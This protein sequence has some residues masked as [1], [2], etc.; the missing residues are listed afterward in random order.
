MTETVWF[1]S[2]PSTALAE[3]E[4]ALRRTAAFSAYVSA[5]AAN[6]TASDANKEQQTMVLRMTSPVASAVPRP[7]M[8]DDTDS[9]GICDN[10]ERM[11]AK[12]LYTP[13]AA[14]LLIC[15]GVGCG[16]PLKVRKDAAPPPDA[17]TTDAPADAPADQPAT[18]DLPAP[19][20]AADPPP[21]DTLPPPGRPK[22]FR[23]D[24][25]TDRRAYVQLDQ[26][27]QGRTL[28]PSGWQDCFFFD[29][30]CLVSCD[31][32]KPGTTCCEQ[33]DAPLPSL[34]VVSPGGSLRIPWDASIRTKALGVCDACECQQRTP[35]TEGSFEAYADVFADYT[36]SPKPCGYDGPSHITMASPR[37]LSVKV[38]TPFTV[39]SDEDD[40][41][42]V[43]SILPVTDA[44]APADASDGGTPADVADSGT[45]GDTGGPDLP[46]D[47]PPVRDALADGLPRA[48]AELAGHTFEI[49]ASNTAPDASAIVGWACRPA[50]RA[51]VYHL[52]FSG[53][54]SE[55]TVVRWDPV[56]EQ[57]LHGTLSS[58]SDSGLVYNLLPTFAGTRLSIRRENG[59]LV[60]QLAELGSGL[61]V[62]ACIES[63]MKQVD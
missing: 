5:R 44:G 34:L 24:N 18:P 29:L 46:A 63:P 58:A 13:F 52:T 23:F 19:D 60:A 35:V 40:V 27:V 14:L 2:T 61:P 8:T 22:A 50:D 43:I 26:T 20:V 15:L 12:C 37:G 16:S 1:A 57:T 25:L 17:G 49:A 36:C 56:Q 41:V 38:S 45:P 6:A 33:C 51:A 7:A 28:G 4:G 31:V 42:L 53:D 32:V 39:P 55:V 30:W 9:P 54:G 21:A 11:P 10:R 3:A 59:V 62:V 48:F 47:A